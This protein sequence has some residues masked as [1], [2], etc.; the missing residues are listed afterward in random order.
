MCIVK[1]ERERGMAEAYRDIGTVDDHLISPALGLVKLA[2]YH[3]EVPRPPSRQPPR[4]SHE[5]TSPDT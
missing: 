2:V 1:C 4:H 5:I 3:A